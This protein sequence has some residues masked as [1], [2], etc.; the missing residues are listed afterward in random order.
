[1]SLLFD[2]HY[3]HARSARA[4]LCP[5]TKTAIITVFLGFSIFFVY[6]A[7]AHAGFFSSFLDFLGFSKTSEIEERSSILI[8][9]TQAASAAMP[10]LDS[11]PNPDG[12]STG[13]ES[14]GLTVVQDSA[15]VAPLNP[16]G[17]MQ[18]DFFA[19][20]QIFIYTVKP[21]DT[22]S[23]IA[24]AFGITVNTLL[25]ANDISNARN[26]RAG[27]KL[28]ILPISGVQIEV[29]SGDTI[30]SIAKKYKGN[31]VDIASFNGFSPDEL[32]AVGITLFIPD[33]EMPWMPSTQSNAPS[34]STFAGLPAYTGYYI[35][36]IQDGIKTQGIHGYNGVDLATSCGA[37]IFASAGGTV[38]ISRET[39]W[40]GGYGKY[41]VISHP[42]GTQTLYAHDGEVYVN[43]G[44][45]VSQGQ[46]I[47]TV[48]NTGNTTAKYSG[49]TGCHV[50][51]EVRG[52]RNPW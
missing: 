49:K 8:R 11:T 41:V 22:P 46:L 23:A 2:G 20:G 9:E 40:N 12:N 21:G 36:P 16:N 18:D 27:D 3:E 26:I 51:F 33:G 38:I 48:G 15:I 37:P 25:W 43:S 4:V 19:P 50:H 42:N 10:V 29:K 17:I 28:I 14:T 52:A 30:D 44:E 32:L 45:Q 39:G 35:R 7:S 24:K 6:P 34:P 31:I 47:A 5:G 1:M 13:A